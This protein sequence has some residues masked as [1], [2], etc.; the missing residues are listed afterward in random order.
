MPVRALTMI[1]LLLIAIGSGGI[2]P[3][4]SAFGGDQFKLPEQIKQLAVFFSVFYFS[5]NLGSFISTSVTPI[6]RDVRCLGEDNCF[7]LAFGVPAILMV[8]SI[9]K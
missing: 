6:L 5:I 4:V 9:R 8:I 1:G 3:C 2:K 7:A